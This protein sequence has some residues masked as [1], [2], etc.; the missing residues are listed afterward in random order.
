MP[1]TSRSRRATVL[2]ASLVANTLASAC[3]GVG[4]ADATA[5][6][7][8]APTAP[9]TP[10]PGPSGGRWVSGYYVGYQRGLYPEG[11]V[12]FSV[13]THVFVGA[14]QPTAAGGVTTDFFLDNTA[15]P[16]MARTLAARA[17]QAGRKAVLMLGGAGYR[18]GLVSATADAT[19]PT[20]VANL[21]RTMDELGY[22]GVDVDWEPI[23]AADKPLVLQL[24]RDLRAARPGMLLTIPVM[25]VGANRGADP[26]YAQVAAV[27]D[28]VNVMSYGM[29]DNWGGW[30]SWHQAAL[31]GEAGNHPSSVAADVRAFRAAGVPAAKL[32]IGLGFYGS[33]WR[34]V[35]AMRQPLD[36]TGARVVASDNAMS[37]ATIVAQY[38]AAAAYRWDDAARA[39]YLSF[40]APTGPQGC[41]LVS[42]EDPRSIAEKGAYVKA[43][44]L[45][46]AILWTI[47]QGR[48]NGAD[49]L[50]RAAY[51]SIVE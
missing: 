33:C 20:F 8:T 39:G 2:V 38:Y 23:E 12:D 24:L 17:H 43:Q 22:D 5:P 49:P 3:G 29:A 18:A 42:Y 40:G 9:T 35:S 6:D 27:V 21:L 26:W 46:G 50:T 30:A 11:E 37:Y 48:V 41:T 19:R 36:G 16:A 4:G 47:N 44:G 14:V 1:T 25:W 15:G 10:P 7:P 32:G 45:G 51:S 28:Q 13:L 34:G 31:A